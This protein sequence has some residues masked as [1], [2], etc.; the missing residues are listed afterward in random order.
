MVI[1]QIKCGGVF[2]YLKFCDIAS[3]LKFTNGFN[4]F[5]YVLCSFYFAYFEKCFLFCFAHPLQ[6]HNANDSSYSQQCCQALFLFICTLASGNGFMS[7]RLR[8]S[9]KGKRGAADLNLRDI[10]KVIEWKQAP[11]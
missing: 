6:R 8:L 5:S 7:E 2:F 1:L 3:C 10:N 4:I 9:L 11:F